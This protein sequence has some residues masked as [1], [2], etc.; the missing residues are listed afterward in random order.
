MLEYVIAIV[1]GFFA[2]LN[3]ACWGIY[4]DCLYEKFRLKGFV[5]GIVG[6]TV[7]GFILWITLTQLGLTPLNWGVFFLLVVAFERFWFEVY[8]LFFRSE[9]QKKYAI[10]QQ[11]HIKGVVV[12]NVAVR[13]VLAML[14][15]IF[16]IGLFL[17]SARQTFSAAA[18]PIFGLV[19]GVLMAIG[20][21]FRDAT[22]EGFK[23]KTFLRSPVLGVIWG[24]VIGLFTSHIG[25]ILYGAIGGERLTS[26]FYKTFIVKRAHGK[27]KIPKDH[28]PLFPGW[29]KHQ[30]KIVVPYVISW[31]VLGI[32]FIWQV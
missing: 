2:G 16:Y 10:P 4:R 31:I 25:L 3:A 29:K 13:F 23:I 9:N 17:I 27:L 1:I 30:K 15:V 24:S 7:I 11:L 18:G 8:K 19:G 22:V 28:H 6:G 12:H 14:F 21:S 32:S 20:G 26:E 5:R